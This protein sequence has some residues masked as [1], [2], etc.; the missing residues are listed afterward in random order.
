MKDLEC[1]NCGGA[2]PV[3]V[4]PGEFRCQ[5]CDT[6]FVNEAMMQRHRAAE[7]QAARIRSENLRAQAQ[8]AQAKAVSS[9]DK[10]VLIIVAIGLLLVFGYVGYMAKKSMDQTQKQQEE[11][12]KSFEQK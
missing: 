11:L 12:M 10:R 2:N 7:K 9:M 5:F 1:P 6:V 8:M 3:T 4:K